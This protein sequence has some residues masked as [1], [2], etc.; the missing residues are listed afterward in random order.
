MIMNEKIGIINCGV[1]NIGSI[2]QSLKIAGMNA[3]EIFDPRDIAQ[4]SK[5]ILPGV[6]A[7][8][9]FMQR[10]RDRGFITPILHHVENQNNI[11]LGICVGMQALCTCGEENVSTSGLDLISGH[12]KKIEISNNLRLPH[13]GWNDVQFVK[14]SLAESSYYF[15]H[16]FSVHLENTD[17]LLA[18]TQ[19]GT[20][21]TAGIQKGNIIG[22]QFHPEKSGAS[23]SRFLAD[24]MNEA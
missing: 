9:H 5:I 24:I 14:K 8:D 4:Y 22:V 6:G 19:Y 10:L 16:S 20:Q 15:T 7:F 12:V 3:D 17:N 1:G 23:G 2:K 13:V 21:I 18:T 11:L